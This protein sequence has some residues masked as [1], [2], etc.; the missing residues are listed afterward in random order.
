MAATP[1]QSTAAF[2]EAINDADLEAAIRCFAKDACL[3]T[4]DSTAIRGREE[5][6]Q[7]LAQLIARESKIEVEAR[8]ILLAGEVAIGSERWVIR[9]A[10]PQGA[11][12]AQTSSP[13]LVLRC[14]EETWKLAIAAPWGWGGGAGGR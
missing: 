14:L 2:V 3:L 7:I 13:T 8:S 10:G 12:F 1:Q 4:P 9:S 11:V 6:R 5:I